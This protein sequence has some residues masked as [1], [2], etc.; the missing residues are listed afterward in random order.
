MKRRALIRHLE[1][2]DCE[3]LREGGNHTVYVN[4]IEKKVTTIAC[5]RTIDENLARKIGKDLGVKG[6]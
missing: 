2:L 5:H 1:N 3:L 6:P 4:R